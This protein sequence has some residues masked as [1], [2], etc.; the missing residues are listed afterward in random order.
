MPEPLTHAFALRALEIHLAFATLVA[1]A[2]WAVTLARRVTATTKY[3]IWVATSIN[4]V[5]PIGVFIERFRP[6]D[7]PWVLPLEDF[8][9]EIARKGTIG[10]AL[11]AGWL[12]GLLWMLLRL[13][14]R[15]RAGR[16]GAE[17]PSVP[18]VSGLPGGFLARGVP[19]LFKASGGVP[20]VDGLLRPRIELPAGIHRLLTAPELDAILIHEL[21]HA[22][23]RDNLIRLV[24]EIAVCAFWFHPLV[25]LAGSRLSLFRELSCDEAAIRGARGED[26][27]SALAK[28]A[29]PAETLLLQAGASS[30]VRDRVAVLAA[31]RRTS[32][33]ANAVQAVIFGAVLLAAIL[34][35]AV[36]SNLMHRA[37]MGE[38]CPRHAGK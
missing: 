14:L 4:F 26:L 24:H 19:V 13:W 8:G 1:F 17:I 23:R 29:N 16:I 22:R 10:A 12:L 9:N 35:S 28:L 37:E 6:P 2:A 33:V 15:I 11:A 27:L 32:A 38:F 3:W 30:F 5:L 7:L 20:A 36:Q 21:T 31:P 34:G 18:P 25:W